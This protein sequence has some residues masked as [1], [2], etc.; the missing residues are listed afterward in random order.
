MKNEPVDLITVHGT[1]AGDAADAGEKWWQRGSEFLERLQACVE[2]PLRIRPFHWSGKNSETDRRRAATR[3]AAAIGGAERP[4]VIG[5]SHG[6]S[7][8]I[9]ALA[10]M[11]LRRRDAAAEAIRAF[12]TIGTPMILFRSNRNP[13]TRYNLY[14][15]ILLLLAIGIGAVYTVEALA[16]IFD[17][18]QFRQPFPHNVVNHVAYFFR[19]AQPWVAL[20][21]MG[22]LY[23]YGRR[24]GLR[25]KLFRSRRLSRIFDGRYEALS[26]TQD[27][28][29]RALS[30]GKDLKP[31]VVQFRTL[32]G[33]LFSLFA[34]G[35]IFM[36]LFSQT[37]GAV[38]SDRHFYGED[39]VIGPPLP[40]MF[41]AADPSAALLDSEASR[42]RPAHHYLLAGKVRTSSSF[43]AANFYDV[44]R[45]RAVEEV[46]RRPDNWWMQMFEYRAKG[47][48]LYAPAENGGGPGVADDEMVERIGADLAAYL[49]LFAPLSAYMRET[50][51]RYEDLFLSFEEESFRD[52]DI[53]DPYYLFGAG[54]L[55]GI[56][57]PQVFE[58][59]PRPT[60]AVRTWIIDRGATDRGNAADPGAARPLSVMSPL[61]LRRLDGLTAKLCNPNWQG[62]GE[63]FDTLPACSIV[64]KVDEPFKEYFLNF[65][66]YKWRVLFIESSSD[67]LR[68]AAQVPI[69]LIS[70]LDP[71]VNIDRMSVEF[72][73]EMDRSLVGKLVFVVIFLVFSAIA[74]TALGFILTPIFQG[75]LTGTLKSTAYGNDGFGEQVSDVRPSLDFAVDKVGTIPP[76]V[77]AEMVANSEADAP[78]AITRLRMLLA[79]AD[80][81]T[82]GGADPLSTAMKF[83][84][85]ELIHNAY[86]QSEKFVL[87]LAALLIARHGLTPTSDFLA[88]PDAKRFLANLS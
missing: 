70:W 39:R 74:A 59:M 66:I 48:I 54:T 28:A 24:N 8:G 20:G 14:G 57:S 78:A 77:E 31:K 19:S 9:H 13:F 17:P 56:V 11:V 62:I 30:R 26:H 53:A 52:Q 84:K 25:Q 88:D 32:F 68:Q 29:I 44:W 63:T 27:E 61:Y 7:V 16:T 83:E 43:V 38:V 42:R 33:G 45:T 35:F 23:W 18:K 79:D 10:L 3:L 40:I 46:I 47:T 72:F 55:E 50:G 69:L 34:F 5:H 6:G 58:G 37:T 51:A 71:S 64:M 65:S 86:F 87:H 1:F 2:E 36:E 85:S 49:E 15:R 75:V 4:I 60:A 21:A 73:D 81:S 12:V 82:L 67:W 41:A 76:E 80:L 22:L